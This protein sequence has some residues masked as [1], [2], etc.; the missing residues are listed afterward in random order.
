MA[1]AA[2]AHRRRA[3]ARV[4]HVFGRSETAAWANFRLYVG[5]EAM[6]RADSASR[7][8]ERPAHAKTPGAYVAVR[9]A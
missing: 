6:L 9:D 5:V 3:A 8:S 4:A 1:V 7:S 2:R